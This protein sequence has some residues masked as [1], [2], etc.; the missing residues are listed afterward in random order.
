MY[1]DISHPSR[2]RCPSPPAYVS[3]DEQVWVPPPQPKMDQQAIL[4][5]MCGS[6]PDLWGDV[7][8]TQ[9]KATAS[10]TS[11]AGVSGQDIKEED[12][13]KK[14]QE[15]IRSG[16]CDR[17]TYYSSVLGSDYPSFSSFLNNRTSSGFGYWGNK[18]PAAKKPKPTWKCDPPTFKF[19]QDEEVL[20]DA[21]PSEPKNSGNKAGKKRSN[22]EEEEDE[23]IQSPF[24]GDRYKK[25]DVDLLVAFANKY[26]KQMNESTAK[27]RKLEEP[28]EGEKKDDE[29]DKES[30]P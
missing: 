12:E 13:K 24:C 11:A 8:M 2:G 26:I 23:W 22:E 28:G 19:G 5:C 17:D 27:R 14:V 6:R 16:T 10:G 4:R 20:D 7:G 9:S 3:P 25:K 30:S 15:S 18:K 1:R 29:S 21:K